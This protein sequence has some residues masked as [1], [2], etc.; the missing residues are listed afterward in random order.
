MKHTP[1]KLV[2][3]RAPPIKDGEALVDEWVKGLCTAQ[4]EA[5]K[6]ISEVS[7][8]TWWQLHPIG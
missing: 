1:Y 7:S 2:L 6:L 4:E 5:R 8:R 3:G